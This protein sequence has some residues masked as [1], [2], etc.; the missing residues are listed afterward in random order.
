LS[1]RKFT[2]VV[3]TNCDADHEDEFNRWYDEV[4]LGDLL[5]VPGIVGARRA[6]LA[7]AQMS[8]VGDGLALIGSDGLSLK[9]KYLACYYIEAA[10]AASVL[11]EVKARSGTPAMQISPYLTEALTL[12]YQDLS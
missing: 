6:V 4:H 1:V 12:M 2:W 3:L 10:E 8:M 9:Y 5:R 11:K 7:D